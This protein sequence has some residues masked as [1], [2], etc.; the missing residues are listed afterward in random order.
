MVMYFS[1]GIRAVLHSL[2]DLVQA[3]LDPSRHSQV[4]TLT[5]VVSVCHRRRPQPLQLYGNSIAVASV[6]RQ[7]SSSCVAATVVT[8]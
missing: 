4:N 8:V 7:H 1:A 6:G 3:L 2:K 5:G